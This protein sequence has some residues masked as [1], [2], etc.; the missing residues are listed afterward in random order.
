MVA[1]WSR[2]EPLAGAWESLGGWKRAQRPGGAGRAQPVGPNRPRRRTGAFAGPRNPNASRW[3]RVPWHTPEA[4]R[5]ADGGLQPR[6]P[7]PGSGS[8]PE[9]SASRPGRVLRCERGTRS[10][11]G[12]APAAI[13]GIRAP[14]ADSPGIDAPSSPSPGCSTTA[15]GSDQPGADVSGAM[16]RAPGDFA[17][18]RGPRL[19]QLTRYKR[20]VG[21][22][23]PSIRS[24]HRLAKGGRSPSSP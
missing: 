6:R 24:R 12:R 14:A 19:A 11:F 17:R 22:S 9:R 3:H 7:A 21:I 13:H 18:S 1:C 2:L 4:A 15:W 10:G 20:G 8:G 23:T 5:F 16:D